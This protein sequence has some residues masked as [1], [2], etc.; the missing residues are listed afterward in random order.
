MKR[1]IFAVLMVLLLTS[2]MASA[3][4]LS[5]LLKASKIDSSKIQEVLQAYQGLPSQSVL[6][7]KFKINLGGTNY[8]SVKPDINDVTLQY[9]IMPHYQCIMQALSEQELEM[10]EQ[11]DPGLHDSFFGVAQRPQL[12]Q[13]EQAGYSMYLFF[14]TAAHPKF[15]DCFKSRTEVTFPMGILK[16]RQTQNGA[17]QTIYSQNPATGSMVTAPI[18]PFQPK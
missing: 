5:K 15:L 11:N 4:D 3:A 8:Y 9:L 16:M 6:E 12:K 10:L 2:G 14:N 7:I 13:A 1:I 18:G 17:D